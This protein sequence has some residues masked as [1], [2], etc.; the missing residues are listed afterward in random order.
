MVRY[1]IHGSKN[2]KSVQLEFRLLIRE[3]DYQSYVFQFKI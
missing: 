3:T 1:L 2:V